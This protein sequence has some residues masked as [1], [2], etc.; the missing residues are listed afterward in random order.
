MVSLFGTGVQYWGRVILFPY[1][2]YCFVESACCLQRIRLTTHESLLGF[3]Y[4]NEV[5]Y[6]RFTIVCLFILGARKRKTHLSSNPKAYL[7]P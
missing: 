5:F 3:D 7:L 1:Y 2:S 4:R 6:F